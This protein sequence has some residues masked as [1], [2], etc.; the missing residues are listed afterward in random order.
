MPPP[1]H[2][3]EPKVTL[4]LE[5]KLLEPKVSTLLINHIYSLCGPFSSSVIICSN[6]GIIRDLLFDFK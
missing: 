6:Y 1:P 3:P 5:L 4:R 2:N